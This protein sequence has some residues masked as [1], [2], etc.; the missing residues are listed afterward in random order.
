VFSRVAFK[1]ISRRGSW[2]AVSLLLFASSFAFAKYEREALSLESSLQERIEGILSKALP[3]SSY[4]VTV[5]VE[6]SEP[7]GNATT[8]QSQ[9]RSRGN[10]GNSFL[11]QR[12]F[13]LPGVPEKKDFVGPQDDQL[14]ETT[15][16][17]FGAETLVRR[18]AISILVAP[19]V[20]NDQIR[21][22]RDFISASI[23]FNPLR[24]D[25]M[26]IQRSPLLKKTTPTTPAAAAAAGSAAAAVDLATRKSVFGGL[27]DR[28]TM[29]LV[30]SLGAIIGVLIVLIVFLFGPVRAFLNRLLTVL[31]RIGEQAAYTVTNAPAKA[32]P[33]AAPGTGKGGDVGSLLSGVHRRAGG[34]GG[35]IP[36]HFIREEQVVKLPMLM[37]QMDVS[38][39]AI[40]LAYLPTEWASRVFGALE[41]SYQ[42]SL[43]KELSQSKE[44]PAEI[45]KEIEAQVKSK[46]PYL[47]GGA[48]W[49]QSVY[50]LTQP[51]T[52]RAILGT[53]NQQSPELA[54]KLR[55][56][57]FFFEDLAILPNAGLRLILQEA[58]ISTIAQALRDEKPELVD[59]IVRRL[60]PAMREILQQ[61]LEL[62]NDDKNASQEAKAKIV[63]M[64]SQMLLERRISFGEK[65]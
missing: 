51:Q 42:T 14:S 15:V 10:G 3:A 49:I 9:S 19:E 24:G 21:G 48:D 8:V 60:P 36:F 5:K 53:L 43:V 56:K 26:D 50:Q 29:M 62:S 64:A 37:K 31:P 22:L 59:A 13:V 7:A 17:T 44:V 32:T 4:I 57:T 18:I 35:D 38:A 47:V 58:G 11:A 52:Q 63:S 45:V 55:R 33:G 54:K 46:L 20:T 12:K 30:V 16:N 25:E 39:A 6:M 1:R 61:E 23:P 40:V 27:N 28:S 65:K 34:S 41:I 2:A